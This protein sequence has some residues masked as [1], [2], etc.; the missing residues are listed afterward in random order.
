MVYYKG[1]AEIAKPFCSKKNMPVHVPEEGAA[2]GSF[3]GEAGRRLT[4]EE[5]K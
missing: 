1:F 3:S 4:K 2:P 5:K